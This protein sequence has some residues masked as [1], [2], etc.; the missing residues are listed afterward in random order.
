MFA[1]WGLFIYFI[2][3]AAVFPTC[4]QHHVVDVLAVANLGTFRSTIRSSSVADLFRQGLKT[5]ILSLTLPC[6]SCQ[7]VGDEGLR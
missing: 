3:A 6:Q 1:L 4:S 5:L 7:G 2:C